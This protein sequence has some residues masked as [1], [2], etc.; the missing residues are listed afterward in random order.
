[1]LGQHNDALRK[2]QLAQL[3]NLVW[4]AAAKE[5]TAALGVGSGGISG[6]RPSSFTGGAGRRDISWEQQQ[7]LRPDRGQKEHQLPG[8]ATLCC[9]LPIGGS[10]GSGGG[11]SDAAAGGKDGAGSGGGSGGGSGEAGSGGDAGGAA[12]LQL[13]LVASDFLEEIR[14]SMCY[15]RAAYG[16]VVAAGHLR[17]VG[18]ALKLIATM[19]MF[20]PIGGEGALAPSKV[21]SIKG[22]MACIVSMCAFCR[23]GGPSRC[24]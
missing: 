2:Q 6:A 23:R 21:Q 15:S 8:K 4:F 5:V 20:D 10:A 24:I 11:R 22:G 17:S 14:D 1:M 12:A 9:V 7:L 16:Y 3:R 13:H 18:D 19:P